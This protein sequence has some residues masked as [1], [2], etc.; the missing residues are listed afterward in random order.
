MARMNTVHP[1]VFAS[2]KAALARKMGRDPL[3]TP[4]DAQ[5]A[6]LVKALLR[7]LLPHLA[8]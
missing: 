1:L 5:Q 3:K 4:K 8:D 6:Q 7:E 2:V